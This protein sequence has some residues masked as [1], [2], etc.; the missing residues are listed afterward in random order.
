[1]MRVMSAEQLY[2][3]MPSSL[4]N[5]IHFLYRRGKLTIAKTTLSRLS[6]NVNVNL[7]FESI[8]SKISR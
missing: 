3:I 5:V 7:P 8:S 2:F 1:M 6:Y 4:K